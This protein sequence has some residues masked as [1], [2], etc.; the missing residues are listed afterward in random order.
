MENRIKSF[1]SLAEIFEKHGFTLYLVGGTVRDYLLGYALEDMDAVTDAT[2][3]QV[4]DFL[5]NVD[6]TFAHLGSLKYKGSDGVKFDIT[7]LRKESGYS[8]SRHPNKVIF[9]SDLEDDYSRRDFTV[10]AMYMD[11]N[12]KIYDF[13]G[14]QK[15]LENRVLRMVGNPD[16][17]L[18]EDPLR[19]LRAIRFHLMYKLKIEKSLEEAMVDRFYLLSNITDAKIKSEM[20]KLDL[21][22]VDPKMKKEIFEQFDVANI[23]GVVK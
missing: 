14:G 13:C 15:D 20:N 17:R 10:N 23:K 6:D 9:V 4:I 16:T 2:P 19:I 12:L 21:S 8:D 22:H 11:K 3:N 7:T 5:P 1:Q 18:K